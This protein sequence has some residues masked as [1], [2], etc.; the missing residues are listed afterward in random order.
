MLG[1]EFVFGGTNLEAPKSYLTLIF[2]QQPTI[3]WLWH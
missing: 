3:L 1:M 2:E